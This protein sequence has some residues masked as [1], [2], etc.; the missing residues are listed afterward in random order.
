[1]MKR[2]IWD[3]VAFFTFVFCSSSLV[4]N[5]AIAD[6]CGCSVLCKRYDGEG[7]IDGN[8][9]CWFNDPFEA[10]MFNR[11]VN[12]DCEGGNR[13][14]DGLNTFTAKICDEDSCQLYCLACDDDPQ[15]SDPE[16]N[17]CQDAP[18]NPVRQR[19]VCDNEGG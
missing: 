19:H 15:Q 18:V 2:Q 13:V 9:K 3:G 10:L 4:L 7:F 17:G 1:M 6:E 8:I 14:E 5:V 16:M 11:C 12:H